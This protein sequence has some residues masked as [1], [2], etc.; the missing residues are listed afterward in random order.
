MNLTR[1]LFLNCGGTHAWVQDG[2]GICMCF[3]ALW[4]QCLS[5]VREFEKRNPAL[6]LLQINVILIN[7]SH[8]III[9]LFKWIILALHDIG[10]GLCFYFSTCVTCFEALLKRDSSLHSSLFQCSVVF[11]SKNNF[12]IC[13]LFNLGLFLSSCRV[14]R[15]VCRFCACGSGLMFALSNDTATVQHPME[16]APSLQSGLSWQTFVLFSVA[17]LNFVLF[18][19]A[20]SNL[21]LFVFR[22]FLIYPF[23]FS[24]CTTYLKVLHFCSSQTF[25]PSCFIMV[26]VYFTFALT[27]LSGIK[28]L[29]SLDINCCTFTVGQLMG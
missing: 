12:L 26:Q 1:S 16:L 3:Q 4:I 8:K 6:F 5:A 25:L 19:I 21:N 29:F 7:S 28:F 13:F 20:V 17:L 9:N 27:I 14:E 24:S 18:S 22:L 11:E 23:E 15:E 10:Y 2:A